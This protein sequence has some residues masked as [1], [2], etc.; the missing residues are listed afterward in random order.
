MLPASDR[1]RKYQVD[2]FLHN[3]KVLGWRHEVRLLQQAMLGRSLS[4]FRPTLERRA[5]TLYPSAKFRRPQRF[6]IFGSHLPLTPRLR[7]SYRAGTLQ[8]HKRTN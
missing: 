2:R 1:N 3:T 7:V 8:P 6:R 5:A 4:F